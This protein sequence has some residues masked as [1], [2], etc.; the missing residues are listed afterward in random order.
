MAK[1]RKEKKEQ[2]GDVIIK[3]PKTKVRQPKKKLLYQDKVITYK[4]DIRYSGKSST[5]E[6]YKNR[7]TATTTDYIPAGSGVDV[8]AQMER[9]LRG[10]RQPPP[11]KQNYLPQG[12][13]SKFK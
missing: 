12:K 4:V 2:K 5:G 6:R 9:Q 7:K 10:E 1:K 13:R 8:I 11:G 3:T